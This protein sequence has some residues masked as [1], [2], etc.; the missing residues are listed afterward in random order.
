M[1]K[2]SGSRSR[3]CNAPAAMKAHFHKP[4]GE[5]AQ[6]KGGRLAFPDRERVGA[7]E[8]L[9]VARA[10]HY[11]CARREGRPPWASLGFTGFQVFAL[12][13]KGTSNDTPSRFVCSTCSGALRRV[14]DVS[15]PPPADRGRGPEAAE[16]RSDSERFGAD[17]R[18]GRWRDGFSRRSRS[19][20]HRRRSRDSSGRC[21]G[22]GWRARCPWSGRCSRA[23][24]SCCGAGGARRC[25]FERSRYER[26]DVCGS[27]ARPRSARR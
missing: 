20:R 4:A 16:G 24:W 18:S 23:G 2:G 1:A 19:Q 10:R 15:L 5:A 12:A 21:D 27:P 13:V 3:T 14:R 22:N 9:Q 11:T 17:D 6:G 26:R 7:C 25:S 8:R